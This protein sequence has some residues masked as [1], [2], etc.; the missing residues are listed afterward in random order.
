[1]SAYTAITV[2]LSSGLG[3]RTECAVQLS[4]RYRSPRTDILKRELDFDHPSSDPIQQIMMPQNA[5]LY[6]EMKL[7]IR[8]LE[9]ICLTGSIGYRVHGSIVI[10]SLIFESFIRATPHP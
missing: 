10:F 5:Y 7:L 9:R 1:M 8:K 4:H 2:P 6:G 3:S